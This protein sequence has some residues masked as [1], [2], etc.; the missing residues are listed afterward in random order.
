MYKNL[1]ATYL[2]VIRWAREHNFQMAAESVEMY[3]NDPRSVP[4][5]EL[6]TMILVP[7]KD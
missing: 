1:S 2:Q 4:K 3:L 5:S 6:K 7:V